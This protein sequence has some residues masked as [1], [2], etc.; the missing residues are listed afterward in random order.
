MSSPLYERAFAALHGFVPLDNSEYPSLS[1]NKSLS[2]NN[3]SDGQNEKVQAQSP[4]RRPKSFWAIFLALSFSEFTR[5]IDAVI[6]PV[7]LPSVV[8]DLSAT[9]TQGY[10]SGSVFLLCQTVFQPVYAGLAD[11]FGNKLLIMLAFFIF[12]GASV[13]AGFSQNPIWMIGARAVSI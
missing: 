6:L 9:T 8:K 5:A 11:A 1:H 2:S 4:S 3:S 13:L 12:A 7:I 10:M